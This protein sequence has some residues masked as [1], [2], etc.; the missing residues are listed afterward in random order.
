MAVK[1]NPKKEFIIY[2]NSPLVEVI[3]EIRFPAD[4]G[5]D[6]R[7]D[8]FQHAVKKEYPKI[9]IPNSQPNKALALEPYRFENESQSEGI[10]L[11][12]NKCAFYQ[13]K[14]EGHQLFIKKFLN[15]INVFKQKFPDVKKINRIG[16]RYINI[17][18]FVREE[19]IVPLRQFLSVGV[20]LPAGV[21]ED[22]QALSIVFATKTKNGTIMTRIETVTEQNTKK[23]AILLDFD[24]SMTE[25]ITFGKLS[26]CV[27]SAHDHTRE[28]FEK[29]ITEDYRKYLRGETV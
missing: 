3:C 1:K 7:R 9:M 6:C 20:D 16:W 4:L 28:L 17:I 15:G 21:T 26:S 2:P 19:G 12:I 13:R 25:K 29:L 11:A 23:E 22:Y 18:P 10:M 8:Q 14:Y 24:F 5:I 27:K